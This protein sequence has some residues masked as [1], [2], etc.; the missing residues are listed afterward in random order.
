MF[1]NELK[2]LHLTFTWQLA[3]SLT[4]RTLTLLTNMIQ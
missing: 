3:S 4:S 2:V 1:A